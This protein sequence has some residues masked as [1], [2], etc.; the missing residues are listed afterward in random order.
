MFAPPS[1]VRPLLGSPNMESSCPPEAAAPATAAPARDAFATEFAAAWAAFPDASE[2][3]TP[4]AAAVSEE[5]PISNEAEPSAAAAVAAPEGAKRAL[6][7]DGDDDRT[8]KAVRSE[9]GEGICRS[10]TNT[11]IDFMG[12]PCSCWRGQQLRSKEAT[13]E[14]GPR[15]APE[16]ESAETEPRAPPASASHTESAERDSRPPASTPQ[17]FM[18]GPMSA[19]GLSEVSGSGSSWMIGGSS[20]ENLADAGVIHGDLDAAPAAARS[21][22][23]RMDQALDGAILPASESDT[24]GRVVVVTG[25]G[26]SGAPDKAGLLAA[27]GLKQAVDDKVLLDEA[28]LTA[29]D[30]STASS[31][32]C[33]MEEEDVEEDEDRRRVK[34]TTAIMSTDLSDH[35]ELNFSEAIVVAPVLYGGRASDGNIVAVLSMRVWT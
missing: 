18:R 15:A 1:V 11:G 5:A 10:C 3:V 7:D 32:F 13:E 28:R 25:A 34:A 8:L 16:T 23:E 26:L 35:F 2:G 30:Y 19:A 21:V 12:K 17:L 20:D 6:T 9:P 24:T 22:A 33:F 31:G 4:A 27:L 14:K 29:K